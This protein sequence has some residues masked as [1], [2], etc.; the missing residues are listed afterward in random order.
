MFVLGSKFHDI[1]VVAM[2]GATKI[3]VVTGPII[4]WQTFEIPALLCSNGRRHSLTLGVND[5]REMNLQ[6]ML[7][8]S[9]DDLVES[10]EVVRLEP[11][12]KD[13]F[14]LIGLNVKNES[15]TR[16]GRVND[17]AINLT[18]FTIQKIY[19]RQPIWKNFMNESLTIDRSQIVDVTLKQITV[20]DAT[21]EEAMPSGQVVTPE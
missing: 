7:I 11:L 8:N 5:I 1:P 3:A 20:R 14:K 2:T 10:S 13:H 6:L 4:N 12:V 19:V 18:N 16:L 15:G 9:E 17:Y 21:I